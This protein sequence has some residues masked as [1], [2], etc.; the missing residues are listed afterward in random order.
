MLYHGKIIAEGTP[1]EI[2]TTTHPVVKNFIEGKAV[3]GIG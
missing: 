2:Q 3:E 1:Q